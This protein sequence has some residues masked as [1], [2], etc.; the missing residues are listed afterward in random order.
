M[1]KRSNLPER[2]ISTLVQ[3]PG[4]KRERI[5]KQLG[6]SYQSVQKHLKKMEKEKIIVPSFS[7]NLDSINKE[8]VFW[9]FISTQNPDQSKNKLDS[10]AGDELGSDYQRELCNEIK[11]SFRKDSEIVSGLVFGGIHIVIGGVYDII[12]Q[13]FSDNPD[14]VGHSDTRFLR[15]R[16]AIASTSTA[17]ALNERTDESSK[18]ADN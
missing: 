5:S 16:P 2:I 4:I 7:V 10:E 8:R 9:I 6:V 3:N 14:S 13:I 18:T 1:P 12:L 17:W 11:E 15:S